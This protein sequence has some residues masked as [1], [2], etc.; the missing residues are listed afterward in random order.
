MPNLRT[1]FVF[2]CHDWEYSDDYRRVCTFLNDA[3]NFWWED[4]SVPEHDPLDTNDM[5]EKNLRDQIRPADVMLVLAGMYTARSVWMDWEMNFALRIGMSIIGIK[6]WGNVQI[7]VVV[8]RNA[9]EIVGWNTGTI[10][11]AIRRY[12]PRH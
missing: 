8:Q 1:Y 2:I 3:P 7:P 5:L 6:P 10:V 12:A 9:K 4:K 11:D